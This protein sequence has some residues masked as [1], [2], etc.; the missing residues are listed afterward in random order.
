MQ[1]PKGGF[2]GKYIASRTVQVSERNGGLFEV[3][4]RLEEFK[5]VKAK[6]PATPIGLELF[7]CWCL[8]LHQDIGLSIG[9]V[10]LISAKP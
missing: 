7:D 3:E 1:H 8:T 4:L 2:A 5:P 10:E 6:F 9:G